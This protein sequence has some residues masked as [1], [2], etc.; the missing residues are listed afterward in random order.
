MTTFRTQWRRALVAVAA[1]VAGLLCVAAIAAGSHNPT[2][3]TGSIVR[4]STSDIG[5]VLDPGLGA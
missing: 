3:N 1:L 4:S 2:S 5:V